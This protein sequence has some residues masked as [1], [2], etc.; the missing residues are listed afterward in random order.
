MKYA[1]A[2]VPA[3][4][5]KLKGLPENDPGRQPLIAYIC[6]L[7]AE[8]AYHHIPELELEHK[9]RVKIIPCKSFRKLV[10][11]FPAN[12]VDVKQTMKQLARESEVEFPEVFVARSEGCVAVGMLYDKILF[13]GFRGT[14]RD[15]YFDWLLNLRANRTHLYT[16]SRHWPQKVYA[17]RPGLF[18][19]GFATEAERVSSVIDNYFTNRLIRD[20]D[21][22]YLT[23][24]SLGGA[25]AAV[26]QEYIRYAPAHVYL[27]GAPRYCDDE[28]YEVLPD[29][30]PRQ[31][32]RT[33]DMV[34]TLPPLWMGYAEHPVQLDLDGNPLK[35]VVTGFL[36]VCL[37]WIAFR[38]NNYE[39]HEMENY[40]RDLG[41]T[42]NIAEPGL[43]LVPFPK[44]NKE[45]LK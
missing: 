19:K 7:F 20:I 43:D 27:Y 13:I 34:P 10:L 3:L 25:V 36:R 18:H 12:G 38:R 30:K 32:H 37:N 17:H 15:S 29:E 8:L 9:K 1:F 4:I 6:A 22:V 21:Q 14:L 39:S 40:R 5:R 44:I 45:H 41:R 42:A 33:G 28:A 2:E 35:P 31:Y 23:G 16:R 11:T 24:H 26:A